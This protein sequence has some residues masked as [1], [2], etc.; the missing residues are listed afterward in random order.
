[1]SGQ[2]LRRKMGHI[3]A[4][5]AGTVATGNPGCLLQLRLGAERHHVPVQV[6]HP[7]ELLAEA[8]GRPSSRS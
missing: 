6:V 7:I 8:Y 2:V 3:A 1:M 4:C 5:G